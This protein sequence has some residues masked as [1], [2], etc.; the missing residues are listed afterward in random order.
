M[1]SNLKTSSNLIIQIPYTEIFTHYET[2]I[3]ITEKNND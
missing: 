3:E 1:G 2:T